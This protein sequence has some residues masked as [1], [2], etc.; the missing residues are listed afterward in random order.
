MSRHRVRAFIIDQENVVCD[1]VTRTML[2]QFE[3]G[4]LKGDAASY[5]DLGDFQIART[6]RL[7]GFLTN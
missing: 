3:V 2:R 5:C 7:S 6:N 1:A 4:H